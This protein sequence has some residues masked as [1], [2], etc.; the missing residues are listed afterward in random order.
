MS[1]LSPEIIEVIR[2]SD[3]QAGDIVHLQID[4]GNLPAHRA[5]QHLIDKRNE[6]NPFFE[7]ATLMVSAKGR[8]RIELVPQPKEGDVIHVAV[9]TS[10]LSEEKED[11][12]LTKIKEQINNTF[13]P[14]KVIYSITEVSIEIGGLIT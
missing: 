4:V 1:D 11:A 10:K 3:L 6:F 9:D 14:A 7:P 2:R 13:E 12:Y 5:K 8:V